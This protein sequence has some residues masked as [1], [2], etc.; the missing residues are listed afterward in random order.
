MPRIAMMP[1]KKTGDY[2][3]NYRKYKFY[4]KKFS[5]FVKKFKWSVDRKVNSYKN[6]F[7]NSKRKHDERGKEFVSIH[8]DKN[9]CRAPAICQ[10]HKVDG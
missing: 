1:Q 8:V 4:R 7:Y 10:K 2:K 5:L 3:Y 6:R 9:G